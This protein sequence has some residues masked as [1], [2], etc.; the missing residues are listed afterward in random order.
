MK[1]SSL[2]S[3]IL[4]GLC[5]ANWTAKA[6]LDT[7]HFNS[8]SSVHSAPWLVGSWLCALVWFAAWIVQI[9]RYVKFRRNG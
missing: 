1:K 5:A 8:P 3:V 4:Y 2:I 9:I 6:I 7:I